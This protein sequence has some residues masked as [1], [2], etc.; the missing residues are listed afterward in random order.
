MSTHPTGRTYKKLAGNPDYDDPTYWNKKFATGQD[1]GEW[2]NAGEPLIEAVIS[3]LQSRPL[4]EPTR[5]KVLHLG[6]GVSKLG[7]KVR[8]SFV[9]QGWAGDGIVNADFSSE[10]VRVGLEA[11]KD[12]DPSEAMHWIH[13]DFRSWDDVASLLPFAPFDVVM[14]KSTSDAIAT[15]ASAT[16]SVADLTSSICPTLREMVEAY[17]DITL[18]PIELLALH[19]VPLT[20]KGTIWASLSYSTVRFDNVPRIATHWALVSRT[21]L[22]APGG[23]TSSFAHVPKIFHWLYILRRK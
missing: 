16:F 9:S 3:D 17:G 22:Q 7:A 5:P 23:Q 10:S 18:S 12:K 21:P 19:L 1:V 2:L 6:P 20:E 15:S 14:D 4:K 11:E 13:V 8:D